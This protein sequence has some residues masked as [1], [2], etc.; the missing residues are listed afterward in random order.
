MGEARIAITLYKARNRMDWIKKQAAAAGEG[1]EKGATATK[2]KAQKMQ[3]ESKLS[4]AK[5]A[6]EKLKGNWGI[7]T[8]DAHRS[9]DAATLAAIADEY[10][11]KIDPLLA[12]IEKLNARLERMKTGDYSEDQ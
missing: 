3:V 2:Q 6:I 11:L 10:I 9:G 7:A 4:D 8:F 5:G 12:T 1:I